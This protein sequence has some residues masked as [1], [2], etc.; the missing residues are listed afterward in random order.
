SW[1]L[2]A[3]RAK[4]IVGARNPIAERN[5][6]MPAEIIELA[7]IEKFA[8][9]AVRLGRVPGQFAIKTNYVANQLRQLADGNVRA[10]ADV[11]DFGRIIFFKKKQTRT[12]R[13]V[14]MKKFAPRFARAPYDKL[15][16]PSHFGFMRLAEKRRQHM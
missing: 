3:V 11:N 8:R 10:R 6:R 14:D 12:G 13:I 16:R 4:P 5:R 15:A 7:N 9:H 2:R 1:L